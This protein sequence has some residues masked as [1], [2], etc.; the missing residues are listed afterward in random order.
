[1]TLNTPITFGDYNE[2][3]EDIKPMKPIINTSFF[4]NG[5]TGIDTGI[6]ENEPKRRGRPRKT[7]MIDGNTIVVDDGSNSN[8][9]NRELTMAESSIP[10]LETYGETM[11]MLRGAV[12]QI[13]YLQ[14][15]LSTDLESIRASKTLKK[16]YDYI[17][18]IGSTIGTLIGSKVTSIREINK[19]ITDCHNLDMKRMKD[20]KSNEVVVDDNKMISDMYKAFVNT[21]VGSYGGQSLPMPT[22]MDLTMLNGGMSGQ[23]IGMVDNMDQYN[24]NLNAISPE[25]NM[26]LLE[27]NPNIKTVF[28]I[29]DASGAKWFDVMDISTGQS[30]PNVTTPDPMFIDNLTIDRYNKIARDTNLNQ[31]YDLVILNED[32]RILNY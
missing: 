28:I 5:G 19:T 24:T 17:S 11:G 18:M 3:K 12:A 16:K 26:M 6:S 29:D 31:V 22:A 23:R 14:G 20:M 8:E 9:S 4:T 25:M 2:P 10:Y 7:E 1:M 21:P 30:I 32:T 27:N 13:D 15:E